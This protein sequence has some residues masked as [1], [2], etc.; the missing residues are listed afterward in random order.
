M[1][2]NKDD[3]IRKKQHA[4]TVKIARAWFQQMIREV[5]VATVG[6]TRTVTLD[7]LETRVREWRP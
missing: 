1:K 3:V 7:E 4:A 5:R 2:R 6:Y